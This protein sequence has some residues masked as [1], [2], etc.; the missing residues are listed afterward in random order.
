M[1]KLLFAAL[2]ITLAVPM[3]CTPKGWKLRLRV[4]TGRVETTPEG[5]RIAVLVAVTDAAGQYPDADVEVTVTNKVD[6]VFITDILI[7]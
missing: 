7:E 4:G 5:S 6:D 1:R 2:I 3:G